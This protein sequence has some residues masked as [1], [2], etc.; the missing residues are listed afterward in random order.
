M[1]DRKTIKLHYSLIHLVLTKS[2]NLVVEVEVK[3]KRTVKATTD[4][5]L[6]AYLY[7]YSMTTT[8]LSPSISYVL[9]SEYQ[10]K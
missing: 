6:T 3:A 7:S 4:H 2:D 5:T 1:R 10:I 9:W 8:Y